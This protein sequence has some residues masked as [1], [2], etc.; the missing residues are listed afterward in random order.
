MRPAAGTSQ[1]P[2]PRNVE[3]LRARA[4]ALAPPGD[5]RPCPLARHHARI[6]HALHGHE[7]AYRWGCP[8]LHGPELLLPVDAGARSTGGLAG[9]LPAPA[10]P[11]PQRRRGE[12]GAGAAA[13]LF[14]GHRVRGAA[15]PVRPRPPRLRRLPLRPGASSGRLVGL[16]ARVRHWAHAGR[17]GGALERRRAGRAGFRQHARPAGDVRLPGLCRRRPGWLAGHVG[18]PRRNRISG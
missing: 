9:G 4:R 12:E 8:G 11:R 1:D 14:G 15:L 6:Q 5:R 13:S 2:G 10:A 16:P 17:L 18:A 3:P 7:S